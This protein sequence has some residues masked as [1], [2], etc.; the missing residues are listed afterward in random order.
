MTSGRGMFVAAALC[1]SP[2]LWWGCGD[3]NNSSSVDRPASESNVLYRGSTLIVFDNA[4]AAQ[5]QSAGEH[6]CGNRGYNLAF[7][8]NYYGRIWLTCGP[9]VPDPT[10]EQP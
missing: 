10:L 2:W 4:P 9:I 6:A 5:V 7:D 1:I 3:D 8:N